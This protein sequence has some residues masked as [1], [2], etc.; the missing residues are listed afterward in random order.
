VPPATPRDGTAP[1]C[2]VTVRDQPEGVAGG[3]GTATPL[4]FALPPPYPAHGGLAMPTVA[5]HR[6]GCLIIRA[7]K[8]ITGPLSHRLAFVEILAAHVTEKNGT[9]QRRPG[10][11]GAQ[12]AV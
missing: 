10:P 6:V 7:N 9:D 1:G 3:S 4:F 8:L 11:A 5:T 2:N 12:P